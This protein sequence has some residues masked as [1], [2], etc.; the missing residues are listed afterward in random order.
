MHIIN[1]NMQ[2]TFQAKKEAKK[3]TEKLKNRAIERGLRFKLARASIS[4]LS[5]FNSLVFKDFLDHKMEIS[6][7]KSLRKMPKLE[8]SSNKFL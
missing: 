6:H 7:G 2:I 8:I 4:S 1:I 3:E 5:I